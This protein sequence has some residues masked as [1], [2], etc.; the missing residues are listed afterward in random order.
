VT[1][2]N[3]TANAA[4]S[5]PLGLEDLLKLGNFRTAL[6]KSGFLAPQAPGILNDNAHRFNLKHSER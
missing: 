4:I 2:E 6:R 1:V 3:P 5:T